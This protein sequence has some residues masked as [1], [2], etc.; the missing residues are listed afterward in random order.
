VLQEKT[1]SFGP[2]VLQTLFKAPNIYVT[3]TKS[4]KLT[5]NELKLWFK[6]LYFPTVGSKSVLLIDSWTTYKNKEMIKSVTPERKSV[7][8]LT[9]PPNTTSFIQPLD[10][11]GFRFLYH[12]FISFVLYIIF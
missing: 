3:A 5:K 4:G 9:I 1:G 10:K 6:D 12:Y 11:Y 7:E 8:I 2:R